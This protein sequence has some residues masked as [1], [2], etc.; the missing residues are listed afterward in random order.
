MYKKSQNLNRLYIAFFLLFLIIVFSIF[1]LMIIDERYTFI[2][3]FFMTIITMATVGYREVYPLSEEG[4]IFTTLLIIFSFGIFGYVLTTITRLVL[5]GEFK[6]QYKN[7]K[8][9]RKIGTLKNHVIVCG[10]GRNGTQAVKELITHKESVIVIEKQNEIIDEIEED[11]RIAYINGDATHDDVLEY[12][13]IDKAKALIT[14]LPNDAENLFI[15]LTARTMNATMT[16]ISRASDDHSDV[17]LK[18]AGATNVIMPDIVGGMRMAM[19]VA[20]PDIVEF[21]ESILLKSGESVNLEE[22]ACQDL[23][24]CF[25]DKTIAELDIRNVSGANLIGLKKDDGSYIYN[26][27]PAIRLTTNYKL[28]AL[29]TPYQIIKL[30]KILIGVS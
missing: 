12:A 18:R 3:A 27:S 16:I 29:G 30:K 4:M 23:K 26:P 14:T 20:Q 5:D 1:G 13:K 17:K 8:V 6:K 22:I 9:K 19:L 15:V 2:Q 24:T 10:F 11:R 21:L 28:F 25:V 7:Y